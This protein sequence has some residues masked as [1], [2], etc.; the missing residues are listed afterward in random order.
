MITCD[1]VGG[2]EGEHGT[3]TVRNTRTHKFFL[4]AS[5]TISQVPTSR[6]KIDHGVAGLGDRDVVFQKD[7]NSEHVCSKLL[8]AYP[9]LK[10]CG[11]FEIMRT[12]AGSCKILEVLPVPP[13]GYNVQYLKSVLQQAKAY[14]R[15]IQKRLSL[16][17]LSED[18]VSI[19]SVFLYC[20]RHIF[21]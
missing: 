4:L 2:I 7:G 18:V 14:V 10:G 9:A 17:P 3:D 6:E 15:P 1:R 21:L 13:G 12:M 16:L 8:E 5:N 19:V 11:G 20:S